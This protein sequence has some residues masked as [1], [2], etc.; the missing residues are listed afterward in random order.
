[1]SPQLFPC[2]TSF[3]YEIPEL[4]F[5]RESDLHT[6]RGH[7]SSPTP[8]FSALYFTSSL[9]EPNWFSRQM[10]GICCRFP[11]AGTCR[12]TWLPRA[13]TQ[14]SSFKLASCSCTVRTCWG[15]WRVPML[16]SPV[17]PNVCMA[18]RCQVLS[19][20]IL[21]LCIL[22]NPVLVSY[23]LSPSGWLVWGVFCIQT[24][25]TQSLWDFLALCPQ[26]IPR[27]FTRPFTSKSSSLAVML[28]NC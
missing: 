28:L 20:F 1:M 15:I 18:C 6:L 4:R 10:I 24:L 26:F 27:I 14:K 8:G 17:L 9:L 5:L 12:S 3:S 23:I 21:H 11:T 7:R 13:E 25:C 19:L 22:W 2:L 16:W